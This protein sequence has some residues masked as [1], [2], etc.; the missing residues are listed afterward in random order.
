MKHTFLL[1]PMSPAIAGFTVFVLLLPL[2]FG[3]LAVSNGPW[4]LGVTAL[5]LLALYTAVWLWFRPTQF[6]LT[7]DSLNIQ[8]PLRNRSILLDNFKAV[9]AL[10]SKAFRAEVGWA[11]R[12]GVG[13]LWGGFGWLWTQH[14]GLVEFYISR[15]N[16]FVYIDRT[17]GYPLLITPVTPHQFVEVLQQTLRIPDS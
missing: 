11:V 2:L 3:G 8:F 9:R 10:D 15:L 13:G 16:E 7:D 14:R 1:A 4:V 5:F 6:T 17:D 12:I